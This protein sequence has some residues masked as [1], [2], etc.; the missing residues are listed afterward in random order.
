MRFEELARERGLVAREVQPCC[1][2]E[3]RGEQAVP[4][5]ACLDHHT[6]VRELRQRI[7]PQPDRL[8]QR[9]QVLG[10]DPSI[11]EVLEAQG[12]NRRSVDDEA[13]AG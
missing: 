10:R 2:L 9:G 8:A 1:G 3:G 11:D 5:A 4:S 7:G 6:F 12:V 13:V